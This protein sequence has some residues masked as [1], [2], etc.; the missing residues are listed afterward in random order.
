MGNVAPLCALHAWL[1]PVVQAL[2][3]VRWFAFAGCVEQAALLRLK[4]WHDLP[5]AA[6]ASQLL[7]HLLPCEFRPCRLYRLAGYRATCIVLSYTSHPFLLAADAHGHFAAARALSVRV[8]ACWKND[9]VA[10]MGA[11]HAGGS[12]VEVVLRSFA[13]AWLPRRPAESLMVPS[14][15]FASFCR[16]SHALVDGVAGLVS[17]PLLASLPTT[18]SQ[19]DT[20]HL[21]THFYVRH[22]KCKS[23]GGCVAG[24]ARDDGDRQCLAT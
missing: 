20:Q 3:C 6:A 9:G 13:G 15:R 7:C 23:R 22:K 24:T 11:A 18:C 4:T 16:Q 19:Q 2:W 1:D 17:A 14:R 12:F 10:V 5:V 21:N 8:L